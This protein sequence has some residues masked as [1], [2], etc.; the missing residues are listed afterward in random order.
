M[1]V[2]VTL[3]VRRHVYNLRSR[4]CFKSLENAFFAGGNKFGLR[5]NHFSVQ[6]NHVHLIVEADDNRALS[7]GMQGLTIRMARS[8]NRVMQRRGS[9]FADRSIHTSS[10]PR[11]KPATP[12]TTS[13]TIGNN[14]PASK[15]DLYS[16]IIVTRILQPFFPQRPAPFCRH[17]PGSSA[18]SRS[19]SLSLSL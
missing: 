1:P 12:S 4:R 3:R 10:A 16:P 5:L 13:C 8:L 6:G 15:D 2:H 11:P 17:P 7:R 18:L 9:V 19:L 14:T